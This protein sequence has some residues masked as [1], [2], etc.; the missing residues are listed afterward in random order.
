MEKFIQ[1]T[2]PLNVEKKLP[3]GSN[4]IKNVKTNRIEDKCVMSFV[5]R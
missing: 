3:E 5:L 1:K 2:V 4:G